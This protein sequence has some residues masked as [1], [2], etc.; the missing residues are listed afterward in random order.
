MK[1]ISFLGDRIS[2][3]GIKP[4]PELVECI[5]HC[6]KPATK[7]EVQRLLGTVNYFSKYLPNLPHQTESLRG[8]LREDVIFEWTRAHDI[9][10][11][12]LNEM[13]TQAPIP[14]MFYPS[15]PTKLAVY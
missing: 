14:A 5:A 4:N 12:H 11:A 13:L 8:L 15:L 3:Q 2:E 7:K 10:W 1:Q 6:Q 9:V